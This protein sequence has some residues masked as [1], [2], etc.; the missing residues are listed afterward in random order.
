MRGTTSAS[1][2]AAAGDASIAALMLRSA[3]A[4]LCWS[5]HAEYYNCR[6]WHSASRACKDGPVRQAKR[7]RELQ[8]TMLK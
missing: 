7:R 8:D 2:R 6:V 4:E 1:S 5:S 3:S